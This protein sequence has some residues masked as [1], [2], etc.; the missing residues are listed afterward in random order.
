[1]ATPEHATVTSDISESGPH[2][3]L[4]PSP[5][6]Q[7]H[8]QLFSME[9]TYSPIDE[10]S[11]DDPDDPN[12]LLVFAYNT[13]S[14]CHHFK[15]IKA[16]SSSSTSPY[17][18]LKTSL[19]VYFDNNIYHSLPADIIP[20]NH[21]KFRLSECSRLQFSSLSSH[22]SSP[23]PYKQLQHRAPVSGR[24][25]AVHPSTS[26]SSLITTAQQ[27]YHLQS[28]PELFTA[29]TPATSTQASCTRPS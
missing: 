7:N 20:L 21:P 10:A 17:H 8:R 25:I 2:D 3:V 22:S 5:S 26:S 6:H 29:M 12:T 28:T 27:L 11:R 19:I 1:M 4:T 18:P 24:E 16:G 23:L 15:C 13:N 9:A 14:V